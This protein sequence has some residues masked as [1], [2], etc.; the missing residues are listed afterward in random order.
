MYKNSGLEEAVKRIGGVGAVA[1]A[2]E[3][4]PA[5]VAAW[6]C[7]P[8]EHVLA[9]EALTGVDRA[10]LRP[11]LYPDTDA[12]VAANRD[13]I[14]L[15]RSAEYALIAAL[16]LQAPDAATL[17]RLAGLQGDTTPLGNAHAALAKAAEAV[18]AETIER[19][20][21]DL[22]IG[23]GRGELLPYA[24]YYLTGFLQ[25]RPLARLREDLSRFGLERADG[26]FDPEDHLGTLCEIMSGFAGG[27]FEASPT[28][29]AAFFAAHVAPWAA[30]CFADLEKADAARFYATVGTL[31]RTFIEIE[32]EGF[33]MEAYESLARTN[34]AT[35]R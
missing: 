7:V 31:G 32:A 1:R 6:K 16:L 21:F 28:E 26:H 27:R 15:A 5:S 33:A 4:A 12:S 8:A 24:S 2:L 19:E 29:E 10:T 34:A 13:E 30:R 23:V 11:D 22:F 3:I 20:Y 25:E 35:G 14:D 9:I 17:A 18:D